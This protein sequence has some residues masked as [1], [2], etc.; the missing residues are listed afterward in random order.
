MRVLFNATVTEFFKQR[1]GMFFVVIGLLFGFMSGNEHHAF[2]VFFLTA[3]F[4]MLYLLVIWFAYTLFCIL[5]LNLVF[6]ERE[7]SFADSQS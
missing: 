5:I 6:G 2:A 3:E 1:A 7:N 4:G